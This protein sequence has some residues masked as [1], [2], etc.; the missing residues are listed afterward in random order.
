M[1]TIIGTNHVSHD[2]LKLVDKA[3]DADIMALEL[4]RGRLHALISKQKTSRSPAVIKQMGV[5][6]YIFL[7]I[8]GTIQ[9]KLGKMTGLTPGS[10]MLHAYNLAKEKNMQVALIDQDFRITMKKFSKMKVRHK[11]K[12]FR[13]LFRPAPKDLRFNPTKIPNQEVIKKAMHYMKE[14]LPEMHKVLVDDR[15]HVMAKRLA[16]LQLMNPDKNIAA[17][18]GAGHVREVA[19][20]S[21]IYLKKLQEE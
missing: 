18:L 13:E 1:I 2:S 15:N 16:K 14:R 11:L 10:E 6:G 9:Q 7:L 20:L 5:A 21:K 8:G 19:E 3:K 12:I 17:V 4:D